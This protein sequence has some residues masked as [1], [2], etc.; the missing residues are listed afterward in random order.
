MVC[1]A[2]A[3]QKAKVSK[4][5]GFWPFES[6]GDKIGDSCLVVILLDMSLHDK[7]VYSANMFKA[8]AAALMQVTN[9]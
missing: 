9:M 3:F 4:S 1:S 7:Q 8:A 6:H 2:I 5:S